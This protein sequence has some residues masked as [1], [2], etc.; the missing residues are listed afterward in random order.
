[1]RNEFAIALASDGTRRCIELALPNE[2]HYNEEHYNLDLVGFNDIELQ[3]LLEAQEG[4]AG[5][6]D[7]IRC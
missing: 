5:L 6:T 1:M 3:R 2:E 4:A 7:E